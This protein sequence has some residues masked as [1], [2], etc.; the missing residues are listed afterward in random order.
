[1]LSKNGEKAKYS[2]SK[3]KIGEI[4]KKLGFI[5]LTATVAVGSLL[6]DDIRVERNP[7]SDKQQ[8][9]LYGKMAKLAAKNKRFA[10][11]KHAP[12][13]RGTSEL[14][15]KGYYASSY[16]IPLAPHFVRE[17]DPMGGHVTIEDGSLWTVSIEDQWIVRSWYG[18]CE[19]TIQ[20]NSLSF[21]NKLT[22]TRPAYKYRLV[23]LYTGESVA[24]NLSLGPLA[25][26]P[27]TRQIATIDYYRGEI[28]LTNG[29]IWKVDLSGP[30]QEIL[31]HWF[32]GNAVIAGTNDTW[33]SL[34]SPN[35]LICVED[36]NWLPAIRIY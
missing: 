13:T 24:A 19:L 27:N 4:M 31:T 32:A 2:S 3:Q 18:R 17:I 23:N 28:F 12:E 21:W 9:K 1:M 16:G 20:P 10:G 29:Q 8:I 36:D 35:I 6:A 11:G 14:A 5:L 7:M 30:C 25:F 26:D 15:E 33:Y 34:G 22:N